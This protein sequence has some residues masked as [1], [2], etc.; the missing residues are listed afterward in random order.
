LKEL[1]K[2]YS[3]LNSKVLEIQYTS[4]EDA[5]DL[6]SQYRLAFRKILDGFDP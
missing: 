5:F 1:A 2:F 4:K 3:E 6:T